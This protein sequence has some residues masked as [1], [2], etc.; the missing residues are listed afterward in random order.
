MSLAIADYICLFT[1]VLTSLT[2]GMI[3]LIPH[4][5]ACRRKQINSLHIMVKKVIMWSCWQDDLH[6]AG[7]QNYQLQLNTTL[8]WTSASKTVSDLFDFLCQAVN[9]SS[10]GGPSKEGQ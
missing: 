3:V 7:G 4:A 2:V 5:A 1:K 9:S 8:A 10:S 6:L